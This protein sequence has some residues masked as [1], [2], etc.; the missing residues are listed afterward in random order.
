MF[1]FFLIGILTDLGTTIFKSAQQL[2][3]AVQEKTI[4]GSFT[5]EQEKFIIDKRIRK[6]Y[7]ETA[8][9]PW[10]GYEQEEEMRKQ[11]LALS[12][13]SHSHFVFSFIKLIPNIFVKRDLKGRLKHIRVQIWIQFYSSH[14]I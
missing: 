11:I 3:Q 14:K 1:S 12:D 2:K 9:L 7:E 6:R 8:V 5:R 10:I 4:L 13:V